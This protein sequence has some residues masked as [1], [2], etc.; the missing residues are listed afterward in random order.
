MV[1][2]ETDGDRSGDRQK[3]QDGHTLFGH[4]V[5]EISVQGKDS[6]NCNVVQ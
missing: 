3:E 1:F 4:V 6:G 5:I 2:G